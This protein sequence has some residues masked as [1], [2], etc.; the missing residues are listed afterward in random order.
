MYVDGCVY[1]SDHPTNLSTQS[2]IHAIIIIMI[3]I[4]THVLEGLDGGLLPE[5]PHAR[6]PDLEGHAERGGLGAL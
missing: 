3:I 6:L 4:I 5:A 1:L 2:S